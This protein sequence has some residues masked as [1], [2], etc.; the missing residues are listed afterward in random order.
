ME[1]EPGYAKGDQKTIWEQVGY[2][3]KKSLQSDNYGLIIICN[4]EVNSQVSNN[5]LVLKNTQQQGVY[6]FPGRYRILEKEVKI[7]TAKG[8][9]L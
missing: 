6:V 2:F 5:L 7:R 3:H 4:P 9:P 1:A 8:S